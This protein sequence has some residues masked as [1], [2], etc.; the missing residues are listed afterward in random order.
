MNGRTSSFPTIDSQSFST[1]AG[2]RPIH[3]KDLNNYRSPIISWFE[4]ITE[5]FLS[6]RGR[7]HRILESLRNNYPIS[8]HGVNLSIGS[9]DPIDTSYLKLL[10]DMIQ[11]YEPFSVSDHFC[12]TGSN[13][14]NSHNLI[15]L[16]LNKFTL[17]SII[18]RIHFVQDYLKRPFVFEN[19]SAYMQRNDDAIPEWEFITEVCQRTG[20]GILLDINNLYVTSKNFNLDP[21]KILTQVPIDKVKQVHLAGYI[22][23]GTHLLDTHSKMVTDPVWKLYDQWLTF[24]KEVPTMIEWDDQ[25]PTLSVLEDEVDKIKKHFLQSK[26]NVDKPKES[27]YEP[28]QRF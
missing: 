26:L 11:K 24:N 19:A 12:W 21:H 25:I 17:D 9:T 13:G 22:D 14:F 2:L 8:F 20:C 27:L 7:P 1:G 5:N 16:P 18:P 4:I 10:K 23:L 6:T 3:Y 28:F 15:P